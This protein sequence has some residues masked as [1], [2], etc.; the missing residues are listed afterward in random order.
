MAITERQTKVN[1]A[2]A[3]A[4]IALQNNHK[5]EW[6]TLLN[7]EYANENISRREPKEQSN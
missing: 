2:R 4:Q 7:Q 6:H 5:D 3:K 1:R